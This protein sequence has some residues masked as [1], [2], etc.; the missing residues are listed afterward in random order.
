MSE[1]V[2]EIDCSRSSE[3]KRHKDSIFLILSGNAK[4]KSEI[5]AK[6]LVIAEKG[7]RCSRNILVSRI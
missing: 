7:Q 6:L 1:N 5:L 4:K 3:L 2:L